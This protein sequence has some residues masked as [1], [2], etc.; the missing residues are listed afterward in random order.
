M[1]KIRPWAASHILPWLPEWGTGARNSSRNSPEGGRC[2]LRREISPFPSPSRGHRRAG[3]LPSLA[4][5]P[6]IEENAPISKG[7]S[8]ARGRGRQGP[9]A[10]AGSGACPLAPGRGQR[11]W[12]AGGAAF[13]PTSPARAAFPGRSVPAPGGKKNHTNNKPTAGA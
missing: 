7:A 3:P 13:S 12:G 11:R 10:A 8:C 1:G 9:G 4:R 6:L 5:G 2:G